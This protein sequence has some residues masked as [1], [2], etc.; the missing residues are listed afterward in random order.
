MAL[1][2][3]KDAAVRQLAED[4]VVYHLLQGRQLSAKGYGKYI[5]A[6]LLQEYGLRDAVGLTNDVYDGWRV[7]E[8]V[9]DQVMLHMPD[10]VPF[11]SKEERRG[12][13]KVV[14]MTK[15][16]VERP[17]AV[18]KYLG[19][20]R[21]EKGLFKIQ[22]VPNG[23]RD[24]MYVFTGP[25][26]SGGSYFSTEFTPGAE[27]NDE[28]KFVLDIKTVNKNEVENGL[29]STN[30][31]DANMPPHTSPDTEGVPTGMSPAEMASL[32]N[33]APA[34]PMPCLLYTSPSPRD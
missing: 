25:Y 30:D 4:L 27:V 31:A 34:A 21:T 11:V 2:Q 32:A 15:K 20:F 24:S 23:S 9:H 14:D 29:D 18:M 10:Y 13:N 26:E 17:T 22:E 33:A 5:P 6:E 3:S 8:A 16:R 7:N 28:F 12:E 1:A 19:W